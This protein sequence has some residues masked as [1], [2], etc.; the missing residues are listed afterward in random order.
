MKIGVTALAREAETRGRTSVISERT[1]LLIT[2]VPIAFALNLAWEYLECQRFFV[3]GT[4]PSSW[5]SLGLATLGDLALTGVA[6]AVIAAITREWTWPL[7]PWRARIWVALLALALILSIAVELRALATGRWSYTPA[8]P[9]LPLTPVSIVPIL[10][11][12]LLFPLSFGLARVLTLR[13]ARKSSA[14]SAKHDLSMNARSRC[15]VGS[16]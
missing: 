6:Y 9:R 11:L 1:L 4:L 8:A 15:S 2:L 16:R 12:A 14:P 13:I 3:H 10:Q 5:S 7:H